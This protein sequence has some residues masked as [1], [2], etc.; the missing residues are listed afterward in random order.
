M[1][2]LKAAAVAARQADQY[3]G[4]SW[5]ERPES[6]PGEE[7]ASGRAVGGWEIEG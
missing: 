2:G 6:E 1:C 5:V 4:V 3:L 7:E